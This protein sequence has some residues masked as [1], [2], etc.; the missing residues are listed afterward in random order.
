MKTS[1]AADYCQTLDSCFHL[2]QFYNKFVA[3]LLSLHNQ[4]KRK[5]ICRTEQTLLLQKQQQQCIC[6]IGQNA[7]TRWCRIGNQSSDISMT[8]SMSSSSRP[9]SKI[10]STS[11]ALTNASDVS[12]SSTTFISMLSSV[13][14]SKLSS[15]L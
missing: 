7:R 5:C 4:S 2:L 10:G 13:L 8:S 9:I 6:R 11:L 12:Q 15:T 1:V 3:A 14:S